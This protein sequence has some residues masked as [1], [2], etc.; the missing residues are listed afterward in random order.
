MTVDV[1]ALAGAALACPSVTRLAGGGPVEVATYLPGRRVH[2]VRLDD[3]VVEIHVVAR[4]GAVLPDV[5]ADVRAA[6]GPLVPGREVS[7]FVDDLDVEAPPA[8]PADAPDAAPA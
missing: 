8:G 5:A 1:D 2:G 7:V 4:F 3:D 6:V